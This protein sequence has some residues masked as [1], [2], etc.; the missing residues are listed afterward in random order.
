MKKI[1]LI[2]ISG[3]GKSTICKNFIKENSEYVLIS[4]DAMREAIMPNHKETYYF[5]VDRFEDSS[6][7]MITESIIT[8]MENLLDRKTMFSISDNTNLKL[9]WLKEDFK[10]NYYKNLEVFLVNDS[11][12][13]D[14]CIERDSKRDFPVG[15]EVIRRQ[16]DFFP[17]MYNHLLDIQDKYN[18]TIKIV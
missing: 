11:Y 15:E 7:F 9:K 3:S 4:R 17:F 5:G 6:R 13:V 2:G 1:Y 18:L 14:L 16:A 8:S 12:N 10:R